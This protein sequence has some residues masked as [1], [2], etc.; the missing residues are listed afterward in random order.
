[1]LNKKAFTLIEVLLVLFTTLLLITLTLPQFTWTAE[2]YHAEVKLRAVM[3][4][5]SFLNKQSKLKNEAFFMEINNQYIRFYQD[6]NQQGPYDRRYEFPDS[7]RF[8][9]Y[10]RVNIYPKRFT[11]PTTIKLNTPRGQKVITIQLG[12]HYV[13]KDSP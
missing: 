1:M 9:R 6:K 13:F 2:D 3:D 10:Q 4:Y 7:C 12:G 11:P 8:N 5:Y